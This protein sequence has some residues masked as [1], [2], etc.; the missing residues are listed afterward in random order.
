MPTTR[1]RTVRRAAAK[2]TILSALDENQPS[3]DSTVPSTSKIINNNSTIN[4]STTTDTQNNIHLPQQPPFQIPND[5]DS[6]NSEDVH[7]LLR[8][9]EKE[10]KRL[11]ENVAIKCCEAINKQHHTYFQKNLQ[12][13][14]SVKKMTIREFNEKYMRKNSH[15]NNGDGDATESDIVALMKSIMI[16]DSSSNT[17][18][19][20][21]STM[22]KKRIRDDVS[23]M[24]ATMNLETPARPLR[25]G[26]HRT[27]G[28]LLRTARRGEKLM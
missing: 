10:V 19:G 16:D 6:T 20:G 3:N 24:S 23:G 18:T 4:S 9:I 12:I 13:E 28:T 27:P 5:F 21:I 11:Q 17:A 22:G 25:V 1:A 8:D 7:I 2:R 14:K 15:P 26:N